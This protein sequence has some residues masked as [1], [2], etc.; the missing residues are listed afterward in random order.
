LGRERS[1][2]RRIQWIERTHADTGEE[3]ARYLRETVR[4]P[5]AHQAVRAYLGLLEASQPVTQ[6]HETYVVLQIDRVRAARTIRQHADRDTGAYAVL[7][8]ELEALAKSLQRAGLEVEGALPPRAVAQVIRLAFDPEAR[9]GLALRGVHQREPGVHPANAWPLATDTAWSTYRT[10]STWHTVY[11]VREWPRSGVGPDF[12]VPLLLQTRAM[13]TVSV[14]M[15][16]IPPGR[17]QRDVEAA[18]VADASDEEIRQRA[19]FMTTFRRVR[20]QQQVLARER[21][22]ADGHSEVRFSAYVAVSAGSPDE[23]ERACAEV[24]Q[25]AGQARLELTRLDG[26]QDV[27]FTYCLPLGRGLR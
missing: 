13:R 11:W 14:V 9:H 5:L 20:E 22:L 25:H 2:V 16:P 24:E 23:L 26:D 18:R 8:R 1:P 12:L 6:R 27:A 17:A 19:G 4:L 7:V 15:E 3:T 21:E 10:G